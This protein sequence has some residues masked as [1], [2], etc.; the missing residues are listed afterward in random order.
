[1]PQ[2]GIRKF[3]LEINGQSRQVE[4]EPEMPLL[5]V[6]RDLLG[7]KGTKYACGVSACGACTVLLDAVPVRCC[8]VTVESAAGKRI[9][10]IEGLGGDHPL[11]QAWLEFQVPQCGYCQSGQIMQALAL[12]ESNPE[13]TREQIRSG[14]SGN[15]CRCGTYPR[16]EAAVL[17][18]ADLLRSKETRP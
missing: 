9:R 8:V 7:L 5:W 16:I 6:L 3:T 14:M 11:Q 13:P 10:T 1:M 15:L 4:A 2:S 17:R 12:L 18:A